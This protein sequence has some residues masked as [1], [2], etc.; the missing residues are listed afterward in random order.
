MG[1]FAESGVLDQAE[2]ETEITAEFERM[3]AQLDDLQKEKDDLLRK[4]A[5]HDFKACQIEALLTLIDEMEGRIAP[6]AIGSRPI[7]TE[8][9]KERYGTY[10]PEIERQ[11]RTY[12]EECKDVADFYERT[13]VHKHKGMITAFS[14]NDVQRYIE[15][16]VIGKKQLAVVFKAGVVVTVEK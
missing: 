15:K 1:R 9:E 2:T 7:P 14:K 10:W 13:A 6:Q 11:L 16:I 12:P 3:K 5:D 4:K 8:T